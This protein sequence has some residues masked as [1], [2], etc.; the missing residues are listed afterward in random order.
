MNKL[1]SKRLIKYELKNAS[2]NIWSIMFG[3]VFPIA[4]GIMIYKASLSTIPEDFHRTFGTI[5]FISFTVMAINSILLIGYATNLSLELEQKVTLRLNLFGI[6][7]KTLVSSKLIAQLIVFTICFLIY[8]I[9]MFIIVGVETPTISGLLIFL[10]SIYLLC[11][12]SFVFG[13]GI[14]NIFQKF[15]PTYAISMVVMMGSI[16]FSG[17]MGIKVEQFP[18][19]VQKISYTLPYTYIAEDFYKVWKGEAYNFVPFIQSLIFF[20]G[21]SVIILLFSFYH[22]RRK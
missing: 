6:S 5:L 15:G 13:H 18:K 10:M 11:G 22:R 12:I 7:Q 14:A 1:L 8:A 9:T 20:G 4:M 17:M 3:L 21:L 19:V 16:L 2:G